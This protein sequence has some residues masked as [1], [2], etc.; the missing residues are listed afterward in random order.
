MEYSRKD[1]WQINK[2]VTELLVKRWIDVTKLR[3]NTTKGNVDIKGAL[4]FSGQEKANMDTPV[5]VINLL[6][7]IDAALKGLPKVR[8][9]SYTLV[10]WAKQGTRWAY[11][12]TRDMMKKD[13]MG[14]GFK[15]Q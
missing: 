11:A 15:K 8:T 1:D 7:K 3:I 9:V 14:Q 13:E 12:P 4:D 6:K 2:H 5:V 10:G